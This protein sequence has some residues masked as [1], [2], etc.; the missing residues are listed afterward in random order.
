MSVSLHATREAA[1]AEPVMRGDYC[2]HSCCPSSH[3][4]IY[5]DANLHPKASASQ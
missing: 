3:K 4:V 2:G 1:L 5:I